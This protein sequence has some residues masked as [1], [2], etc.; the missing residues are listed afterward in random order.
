LQ[1]YDDF[2]GW[3]GTMCNTQLWNVV[4][5]TPGVNGEQETY[6]YSTDNVHQS[7]ANG[8]SLEIIPWRDGSVPGGWTSGRIESQ[9]EF[10]PQ[11]GMLTLVEAN[12]RFGDN[13]SGN[14]QGIWPAFWML[15]ADFRDYGV[16][17]PQCGE[18]DVMEN[19]NGQN[20]GYGTG[21]CGSNWQGGPCNEPTGLSGQAWIP[22][23]DYHN[24]RVVW[25]RTSG[26]W[27]R[28]TITWYL[29]NNQF[30]QIV[31]GNVGDFN[32]WSSMAHN[33]MY[34]I[35]NVAVGGVWV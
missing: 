32:A 33:S 7:G 21:H 13:P 14:K 27:T 2:S 4:D 24:W 5:G 20:V 28:E 17:W 30:Q 18:V 1:W 23:L 12:L 8:G 29:D 9:Y 31:G 34:I 6:R 22:D 15:G 25:D 10:T 19:I 3:G 26:D 16:P 35:F 11:D